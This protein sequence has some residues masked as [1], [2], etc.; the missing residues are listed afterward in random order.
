MT[1]NVILC[2]FIPEHYDA[3]IY[4]SMFVQTVLA[5]W[6][7]YFRTGLLKDIDIEDLFTVEYNI[8][9]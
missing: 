3:F 7:R 5:Q 4:L 1:V 6:N 8:T 2:Y 9:T